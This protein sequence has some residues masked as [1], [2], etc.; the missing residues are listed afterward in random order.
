MRWVYSFGGGDAD[1]GRDDQALLG[2]KGARLGEMSRIG[3][4]VPPGFTVTTE[5]CRAYLRTGE[6]PPD[7]WREIEGAMARLAD[8]TGRRFGDDRTEPLLVS[9]GNGAALPLPGMIDTIPNIGSTEA[10]IGALVRAA[11]ERFAGDCFGRF[12]R[13][14]GE[15]VAGVERFTIERALADA[16]ASA[17]SGCDAVSGA[18]ALRSLVEA[19]RVLVREASGREIPADPWAQLRAAV[20]AAFRSWGPRL[21]RDHRRVHPI[22]G[23]LGTAVNVMTMVYG[24]RSEDSASGAAST[25]D[26]VTG[27]AGLCGE[28]VWNAGGED[29][30]AVARDPRPIVELAERFPEVRREL[31]QVRRILE[32]YY[33]DM[34]DF[35]FILERG[36]LF[37]LRTRTGERTGPAAVRIAEDMADEGLI[38]RHTASLRVAGGGMVSRG[39]WTVDGPAKRVAGDSFDVAAWTSRRSRGTPDSTRLGP[40]DA[41]PDDPRDHG[42]AEDQEQVPGLEGDRAQDCGE[43]GPADR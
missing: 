12:A 35:E 21:A 18:A 23:D 43:R 2:W 25:R 15:F 6:P 3:L 1:G 26:P 42:K 7:L 36:E 19:F 30:M 38:D 14:Y 29:G 39:S 24:N 28:F 8:R 11:G 41:L 40:I 27:E 32:S 34:Q 22:R 5:A 10:S 31:E 16:K 4:N 33:R 17:A 20:H 37:I 9:V 13:L